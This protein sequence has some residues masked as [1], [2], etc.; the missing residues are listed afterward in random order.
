MDLDLQR[1]QQKQKKSLLP[2]LFLHVPD[3]LNCQGNERYG[4]LA[5][6]CGNTAL[7]GFGGHIIVHD[8]GRGFVEGVELFRM[9]QTTVLGRYPI[10]FHLLGDCPEC[11]F[12]RSSVHRS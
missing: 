8:G 4:D 5:R 6:P 11:Y 1:K 10:H 12:K 3:P 9:G 2:T 7:T